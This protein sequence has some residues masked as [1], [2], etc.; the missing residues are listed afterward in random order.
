[1]AQGQLVY[2]S[3]RMKSDFSSKIYKIEFELKWINNLCARTKAIELIEENRPK[4]LPLNLS[5]IS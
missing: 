3:K 4:A 5:V 2:Q 1:M